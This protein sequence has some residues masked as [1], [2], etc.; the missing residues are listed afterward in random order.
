VRLFAAREGG[1]ALCATWDGEGACIL[2]PFILRDLAA[3]AWWSPELGAAAD[4]SSPYG[5]GGPWT[6]GDG[7]V[8]SAAAGF[9]SALDGWY[10]AQGV[11]AEF[12]RFGLAPARL[13]PYPGERTERQGNVVRSLAP[14]PD[15]LWM[16]Y[17]HKVRKNVKKAQRSGVTVQVDATGER[18]DAFLDIYFATMDRRGAGSGYYFPREFFQAICTELLGQFAF[19]Y[20]EHGGR[21][22]SSELVLVSERAAYS[23]LG[24]TRDD[25]FDLRPNDLVKHHVILWAREQG[26]DRFVLGGGYQPDDGIFRY[27]L[28][29][30]PGGVVPFHTGA[31]LLDAERAGVLVRARH[32]HAAAAGTEWAPRPGYFPPYRG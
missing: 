22:V 23:F 26:R 11:V 18:L 17:E 24:G 30:A 28:S 6:W 27:K 4:V 9:W 21:V 5:Y 2:F 32:R 14:D 7:P 15:A 1:R 13:A 19:L 25:A 16:D 8:E 12:V 31:R 20:A 10:G 3:E 29:F